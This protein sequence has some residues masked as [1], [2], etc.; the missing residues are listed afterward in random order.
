LLPFVAPF[1]F[2]MSMLEEKSH[3]LKLDP[4]YM[5]HKIKIDFLRG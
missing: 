1:A 4:I 3:N 2:D 5:L